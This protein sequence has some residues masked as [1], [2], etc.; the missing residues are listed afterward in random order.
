MP[1]GK[2]ALVTG[3]LD[4]IGFAAAKALA[5]LGAA[6]TLNGFG[7][8]EAIEARL[9]TLRAAGVRARHH[10]A[11]LRDP[12]QIEDLVASTAREHGGPDIVVNNAV[13]RY[14]GA[15]EDLSPAQWN[16]ALAVNLSA[17]FHAIRLSLPGMK[18]AGWAAS[19]TWPPSTA[20][21]RPSTA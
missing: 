15:T 16:E 17:P 5:G 7:P 12:A 6:V 18:R 13:V 21:S 2:S 20:C 3:S 11:D 19:S 4:G 8:P 9:A 1:H 10:P 14:F